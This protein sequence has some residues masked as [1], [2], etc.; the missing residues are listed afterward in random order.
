[1]PSRATRFAI[2]LAATGVA[3]GLMDTVQAQTTAAGPGPRY[4]TWA[5]RPT[6]TTPAGVIAAEA[7][8]KAQTEPEPAPAPTRRA[9]IPRQVAPTQAVSRPALQPTPTPQRVSRGPTPASVWL[10]PQPV[11]AFALGAPDP[12]AYTRETPAPAA[13]ADSTT[14]PVWSSAPVLQPQPEDRPQA[15]PSAAPAAPRPADPAAV[16]DPMAPRADAPIFRLRPQAALPQPQPAAASDP[17]APQVYAEAAAPVP[18]LARPGQQTSRYYS[19][20]REAGHAPD[21]TPLPEAVFYDSVALDLAEPPETELPQRDAQGR[22]R[23][24]VRDEDP[25]RP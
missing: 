7:E 16:A 4:M 5:G 24:P 1:M 10:D 14:Q 19:V 11:P 25:E 21:R 22:L 23:P 6:T 3:G 9:M 17:A 12:L 8:T 2:L 18:A 20:H 13:A 15:V